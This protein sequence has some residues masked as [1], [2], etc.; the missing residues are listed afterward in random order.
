[1]G[2]IDMAVSRGVYIEYNC[3]YRL[4]PIELWRNIREDKKVIGVNG[5]SVDEAGRFLDEIARGVPPTTS[6]GLN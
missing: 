3:Q 6:G 5:H 1:M 4:P 2:L